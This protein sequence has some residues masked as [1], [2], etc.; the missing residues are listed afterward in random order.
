MK[1][2]WTDIVKIASAT[3]GTGLAV[4]A[5]VV[6]I[7]SSDVRCWAGIDSVDKC[8]PSVTI[9][10]EGSTSMININQSIANA[11]TKKIPNTTINTHTSSSKQGIK[12]LI[13][14]K[15]TIAAV[16]R[17]ITDEEKAT[18][19][20]L[21]EAVV[22]NKIAVI[23]GRNNPVWR[24]S[25]SQLKMIF[26]GQITNWADV[27]KGYSKKIKVINRPP[28]SGTHQEFKKLALD[29]E[30]FGATPNIETLPIDA[31]IPIIKKLNDDGI[32]YA[33]FNQI[34]KQKTV[35]PVLIDEFWP[36]EKSYSLKRKF[37]YV[38]LAEDKSNEAVKRWMDYVKSPEGKQVIQMAMEDSTE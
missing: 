12:D 8:T 9:V 18:G 7:I 25:R 29:D 6:P 13:N 16:S 38:Y 27:R 35:H 32:S 11:L 4:A 15:I 37:Y 23:V 1:V 14:N 3:L 24:L 10:V 26:Q 36:A 28:E 5:I 19:L 20:L 30:E 2:Q 21:A 31:T 22:E 34:D 17:P 33:S